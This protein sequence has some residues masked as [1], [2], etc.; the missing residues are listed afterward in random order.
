MGVFQRVCVYIYT[1]LQIDSNYWICSGIQ[2]MECK[3]SVQEAGMLPLYFKR[4]VDL[5]VQLCRILLFKVAYEETTIP[6]SWC[7]KRLVYFRTVSMTWVKILLPILPCCWWGNYLIGQ[8]A[9][10]V[11]LLSL[12]GRRNSPL[13]FFCYF[14]KKHED[15]SGN[16]WSFF[17]QLK[18]S[19]F[20]YFID[21]YHFVELERCSVSWWIQK[22]LAYSD[23]SI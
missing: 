1:Y 16:L 3:F 20:P 13:F 2:L 10:S 23:L 15:T 18:D 14:Q 22:H 8:S 11:F 6:M 17:F 9:V 21:C 7:M 4:S 5:G 19:I 12:A